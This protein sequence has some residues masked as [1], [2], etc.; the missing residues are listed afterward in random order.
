[1]ATRAEGAELYRVYMKYKTE[2]VVEA[3]DLRFLRILEDSA[4][5]EYSL[6]DGA[7]YAK[8]IRWLCRS[9]PEPSPP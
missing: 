4:R 6:H 3:E 7:V 9:P 5:V 1:M 2:R 8:S